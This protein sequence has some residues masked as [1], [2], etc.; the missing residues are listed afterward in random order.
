MVLSPY[1]TGKMKGR[2]EIRGSEDGCEVDV[3]IVR[4]MQPRGSL[5]PISEYATL[6]V[7]G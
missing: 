7:M 4:E 6:A 5:T 3:E 2:R 1:A